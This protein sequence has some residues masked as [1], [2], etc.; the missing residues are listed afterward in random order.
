V[1][2]HLVFEDRPFQPAPGPGSCG[3]GRSGRA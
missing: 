1:A 3:R 2:D